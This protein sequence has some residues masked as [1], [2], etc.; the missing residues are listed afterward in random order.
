MFW[1]CCF[2]IYFIILLAFPGVFHV[3]SWN[4]KLCYTSHFLW[5]KLISKTSLLPVL[6]TAK[7]LVT[8]FS[9]SLFLLLF[10]IL[11]QITCCRNVS[12]GLC[13]YE[14]FARFK[15]KRSN[16]L[17]LLSFSKLQSKRNLT[18]LINADTLQ[19]IL[20]SMLKAGQKVTENTDHMYCRE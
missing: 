1:Y 15:E 3:L 12:L 6:Y 18:Q 2:I 17:S 14:T 9:L 7:Y 16:R 11:V 10:F 4:T 8:I 20:Q 19:A 5:V 13:F